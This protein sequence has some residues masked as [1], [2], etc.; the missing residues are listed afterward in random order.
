MAQ[1]LLQ[2]L[3]GAEAE[4]RESNPAW[5]RKL[6]DWENWK[7]RSKDRERQAEKAK[8]QKKDSD[9]PEETASRSWESSFDPSDPS[10][11]FSFAGTH[12][13]SS[14]DLAE[15]IEE[16]SRWTS[17]PQWALHA[18]ARGIAVHHAGM[19]KRYRSLVE[20]FVPVSR[21]S[22]L[23]THYPLVTVF[24]GRDILGSSLQL[25]CFSRFADDGNR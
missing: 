3:A 14:S 8:K 17:T 11:Q 24:S 23:A 2:A 1:T 9:V 7:S 4:W 13:Y 10:E 21:E 12:S 19:N 22:C 18:L 25:V 20:G 15:D 16:L 6:R 5:Q